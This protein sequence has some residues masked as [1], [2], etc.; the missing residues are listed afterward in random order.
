MTMS[1]V[2]KFQYMM[3]II[4]IGIFYLLAFFA[5]ENRE[6]SL[7][8]I[9]CGIDK[10]IPF[11]EY[12]IVPY[13]LWFFYVAAT[14][15]YFL[16]GNDSEREFKDLYYTLIAGMVV[17]LLISYFYPNGQVLRPEIIGDNIFKKLVLFLYETDTSTNIL[18]SLHVFYS[19]ACGLAWEKNEKWNRKKGFM[20]GIRILTMSIVLSTMFL[21]QH[22]FIDVA[23]A[24]I[25]NGICYQ[26]FYAKAYSGVNVG[27][28]HKKKK[29]E[30]IKL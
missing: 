8:I 27:A 23:M 18:P 26:I 20:A 11:C 4:C 25:M 9:Q 12:F 2:H 29:V 15:L 19:V 21:K 22:S 10:W 16:F 7:H 24:L 3:K 17:F 14:G 30:G 1:N 13:L 28:Q 5:L 6:I